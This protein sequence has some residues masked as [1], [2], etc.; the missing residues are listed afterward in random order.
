MLNILQKYYKRVLREFLQDYNMGS[1]E[2][3]RNVVDESKESGNKNKDFFS[4]DIFVERVTEA[5]KERGITYTELTEILNDRVGFK[6]TKGNLKMYITNRAPNTNF[7]IALSKALSV[8]MDFLCGNDE[9]QREM[10]KGI[11]Y[12]LDTQRY[13]KYLGDYTL[14][15]YNTISGSTHEL[16][17][18]RL[19]ISYSTQYDVHMAI[20]TD[21]G[22][23]KDYKGKLMLSDGSPN[24][25]ITLH[26]DFGEV[27][28]LVMFDQSLTYSKIHCSIGCMVSVS[29]GNFQR[30]PV[31]NRFVMTDYTVPNENLDII[32]SQLMLNSKYIDVP[33]NKLEEAVNSAFTQEESKKAQQILHRLRAAFGTHEYLSIE[34]SYISNVIGREFELDDI[35]A[36]R[37]VA[38]LRLSSMALVN[39]KINKNLDGKIFEATRKRI[40]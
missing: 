38:K 25:Y 33:V 20:D 37:L 23:V 10:L 35:A 3:R 17:K 22:A 7:L 27:V 5:M 13:K 21:E 16:K 40:I 2:R 6:I 31:M 14:Y 29:S 30:S 18:A 4:Q 28:T 19:S 15:F 8:S 36:E 26:A 12:R 9:V 34:E 24:A 1:V 32:R 11:S 39:N